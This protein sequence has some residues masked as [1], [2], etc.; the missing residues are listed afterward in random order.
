MANPLVQL[1]DEGVSPWLDNLS[2]DMFTTGSLEKLIR[3]DGIKGQTSNPTIFQK[4]ISQGSL[5]DDQIVG[6]ARQGMNAED[7]VWEIM[8]TDVRTA[9]DVFRPLYESTGGKHGHVS[10]ELNPTMAHDTAGSLAQAKQLVQRV[11]RPNLFIK[12]P[13]TPE[14]LPVIT[15]L[16]SEGVNVNVTLLFSVDVYE[17]VIE[18]YFAGLEKRLE[19]GGSVAGLQSVASFFV[20]R[21]D[22][23]ADKRMDKR[24]AEDASLKP[25]IDALKGKVAV[26]NARIA[27]ELFE[28]KFS[29]ER[30][31]KLKAK[32]ALV[33]RPLWAST[34]TKNKAYSDTLYVAELV[35]PEC[36]N[37]MPDETIDAFRDHGVVKRTLTAGTIADAHQ[38]CQEFADLGFDLSDITKNTL[39][40]EGVQKF[41]DS[42]NELVEA[43]RVEREKLLASRQ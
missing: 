1:N 37:T 13:G 20:S 23:E 4:A 14:G 6:L 7:I 25:R 34:G 42:Y 12:V 31:E 32:G 33:Q 18:A 40:K 9:C 27:Y 41:A 35:G 43:V 10:L 38:V 15:E 28:R 5:Y 16:L 2:R 19:K 36:V 21:V 30:W 11:D 22:T 29:G 3:E 17:Q 8:V 24:A 26:A 39:V